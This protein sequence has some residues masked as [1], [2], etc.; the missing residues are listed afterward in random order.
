MGLDS[1][2][3]S[4]FAKLVNQDTKKDSESTVYGTIRTDSNGNKYVQL[5]GSDQLTPLA[6]E[7]R[8]SVDTT[9]ANANDGDRVSVLIKNH[10]ATVTGNISSPAV[11]NDDFKELDDQVTEIKQFDIVIAEKV[12]ANEGYIK[13]LEVDKLN[14]GDF[15]AAKAEIDE[16]ISD[17]IGAEELEVTKA[18]ITDLIATKIDADVVITDNA[19]VEHLKASTTDVLSLIADK[20]VIEDLIAN[21]VDLNS[22]EAKNAYLKFANIDFSNIGEAAIE[23]LFADSGI[24]KD[25]IVSEG[26]ITGELVG[27]TIKGDLIEAGTL[28]ADKLVVLGEDGLYYKLNVN[29][30]GE[31]TASSDEKYQNGLDGSIIVAESITAEKIAVNDLVAFGATI[32][33]FH[34]TDN[35][36]V[37]SI[38]SGA[39]AS[40]DSDICGIYLDSNGQFVV[41]DGDNHIKFVRDEAG[42]YSLDISI[43][44]ALN[45]RLNDYYIDMN[46]TTEQIYSAIGSLETET[47]KSVDDLNDAVASIR[48]DVA[49]AVTPD[50]VQLE[51]RKVIDNGVAKVDTGT[52]FT[53]DESGITVN[54]IDSNNNPISPT[55]TN[56]NENGMK[57]TDNITGDDVLTANSNGV[58]AKNLD[59]TTYLIIGGRSRFENYGNNRTGCFWIGGSE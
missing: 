30:L 54:K 44:N 23:K 33:R 52:G 18:E 51:I 31:A 32:G 27:I 14:V 6:E 29:A 20:A 46:R 41:G 5:D 59:A 26:K 58:N 39:K 4:Q 35:D 22:V 15:N 57:I 16:L 50:N 37:G 17:K 11:R 3:I 56:I 24:I 12:Q 13:S 2:L 9:T 53:F 45:D 49:L 36:G 47:S 19:I 25:L 48:K 21:N 38:Y 7:N 1:S 8:P 40:A 10:T 28:K 55:K 42:N 34:I 43:A